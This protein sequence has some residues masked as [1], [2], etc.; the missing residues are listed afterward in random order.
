MAKSRANCQ[1]A[2]EQLTAWLKTS[3]LRLSAQKTRICH[4]EEG[5][6]F[7]EVNINVGSTQGRNVAKYC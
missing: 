1:Q 6:D 2:I 5:I 7:L 3:G 4:I